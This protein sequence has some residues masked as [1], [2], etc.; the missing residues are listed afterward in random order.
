MTITI[1]LWLPIAFLAIGLVLWLPLEY[2]AYRRTY[3]PSINHQGFWAGIWKGLKR[4]PFT[5][6]LV[7]LS[8][9]YILWV[10]FK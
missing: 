5:P 8:W 6:L 7:M 4:R 9:P 1:P 2:R 10:E 3:K